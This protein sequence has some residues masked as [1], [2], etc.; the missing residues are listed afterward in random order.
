[1]GA[2]CSRAVDAAFFAH[3]RQAGESYWA[4]AWQAV[5]IAAWMQAGAAAALVHAAVPG[6]FSATASSLARKVVGSVARRQNACPPP[7]TPPALREPACPHG[8]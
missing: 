2:S 8:A 3:P 6:L 5:R 4:H 7:V 1:M